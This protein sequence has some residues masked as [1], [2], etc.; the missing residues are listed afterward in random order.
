L[1]PQRLG[2]LRR[3]WSR[4]T[5]CLDPSVP[6]HSAGFVVAPRC[7]RKCH[8]LSRGGTSGRRFAR[9]RNAPEDSAKEHR[10]TI[11][12]RSHRASASD[13]AASARWSSGEKKVAIKLPLPLMKFMP[14]CDWGSIAAGGFLLILRQNLVLP[15]S[16]PYGC[17]GRGQGPERDRA[18]RGLQPSLRNFGGSKLP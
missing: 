11:S 16:H 15:R 4:Q 12:R 6:L 3:S 7:G 14:L 9:D 2:R 17:R 1:V 8:R 10:C 5:R 18:Q 13:H